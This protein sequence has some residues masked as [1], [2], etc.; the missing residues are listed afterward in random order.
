MRLTQHLNEALNTSLEEILQVLWDN[1]MPFIKDQI[2][3]GAMDKGMMLYSG[4]S[5]VQKGNSNYF[6][7]PVRKDRAPLD[8]SRYHHN[9]LDDLFNKKYGWKAR[10]N[11]IF[12][13]GRAAFAAGYGAVYMIFPIDRYKTIYNP[14]IKDL[15]LTVEDA[16]NSY[17]T[18]FV[19]WM[20]KNKFEEVVAHGKKS[21]APGKYD[22]NDP[23]QVKDLDKDVRRRTMMSSGR[24]WAWALLKKYNKEVMPYY[25]KNVLSKI[26]NGYKSDNLKKAAESGV[27]VM[28][29]SKE[30]VAVSDGY[31]KALVQW[32]NDNGFKKEPTTENIQKWMDK[33]GW[34][35]PIYDVR[36]F[37][38]NK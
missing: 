3:S 16:D 24:M 13:T 32:F 15:L 20:I 38:D 37:K 14:N 34:K 19:D 7:K 6:I 4:R 26:V 25:S 29:T 33:K 1:S 22:L 17:T 12:V 18:Y 8:M 31:K 11:S 35:S 28:M 5:F 21:L 9:A 30:Y 10:S 27:E 36:V 2:T 23:E